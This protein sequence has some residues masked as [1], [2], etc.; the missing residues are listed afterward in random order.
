[1]QRS[2][3]TGLFVLFL[4]LCMTALATRPVAG[5]PLSPRWG[6]GFNTMISSEESGVFGFGIR[7]RASFP[8]NQDL[9]FAASAG[10][11]GFVLSGYEDGS[12]VFDPQVSAIITLPSQGRF[13]TYFLGG[14]G[15]YLTTSDSGLS[16]ITL[17]LGLGRVQ[18]LNE[19]TI[20]YEVNPALIIGSSRVGGAVPIRVG[21]IF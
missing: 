1:M 21:I 9:S 4:V 15:S 8:Y 20:F 12:F 17:H 5:Q 16:G 10:F 14:F 7:G 3:R 13:A 6:L 11:T 19:T 18:L 2:L